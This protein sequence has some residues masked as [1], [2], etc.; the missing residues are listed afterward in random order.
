[1]KTKTFD[2][3]QMKRQASARIYETIKGMTV[4]EEVEYWRKHTEDLRVQQEV[5]KQQRANVGAAA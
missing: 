3:V 4:E 2:C 5:A 1:M